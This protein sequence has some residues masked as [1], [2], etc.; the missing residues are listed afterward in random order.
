MTDEVVTQLYRALVE[1]L[2]ERGYAEERPLKVS[3]LYEELV[4]YQSVRAALGVELNADYEHTLLRLLAGER[5]LLRLEPESARAEL[6]REVEAPF[7]AVGLFRKF[8]SSDVWVS[9]PTD[10][11]PPR[12]SEPVHARVAD[13][14]PPTGDA[15]ASSAPPAAQISNHRVTP[16]TSAARGRPALAAVR[17]HDPDPPPPDS[18]AVPSTAPDCTFCGHELPDGRRV[19]YCPYCGGDQRLRPCPRCQAVLERDWL[20][21]ISCG[22]HVGGS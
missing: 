19:R 2:R 10:P 15:P 6:R 4:P 20:Y 11:D 18:V 5:G 8:S 1:A 17:I 7:P 16:M 21:C 13:P 12:S 3:E 14:A 22:H 9:M